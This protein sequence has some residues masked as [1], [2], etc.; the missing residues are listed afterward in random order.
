MDKI[1][2]GQQIKEVF[3]NPFDEKQFRY[4]I[5][6]LF[7]EIEELAEPPIA[8]SYIPDAFKDH[9]K[10]YKRIAKYTDPEGEKL[11]VLAV[12]LKKDHSIERART[13]QRNFLADYL[14]RRG[15]KD[16]AL[17][18]YYT[19]G[20]EDWRFSY[21]RMDYRIEKVD[22]GKVKVKTDLT[23]AR[24]Y[25]F[26][27]GKNE[28]SH[29]AQQQLVPLLQDIDNNP[30]LARIEQ[31]FNIESVTKEFYQKYKE[32]YLNL[33]DNCIEKEIKRSKQFREELNSKGIDEVSFTKKLLGQIV[34]LYF[35]QKK[36][37][38]GVP[39]DKTWGNGDRRYLRTL[40]DKAI[41]LNQNFY[42][43]Y[44]EYLF[45]QALATEHRGGSDSSYYPRFDC[46]IPF[47]NGGLFEADYDWEKT[48]ITIPNNL[49][50]NKNKTK[51]GDEGDGILD[52][53][54]R[55]N[56][57]VKEDEPLDKEVAV[58]PEMLGKVFENLLEV[59][60]RKSKGTY[61]TPREIV[62]YMCQESLI[63]YLDVTLNSHPASYIKIGDEQTDAF[64]N[65]TKKGQLDLEEKTG[66]VVK[67]PKND[68][69]E[70]IR[71]GIAALE[72]DVRVESKG[73]ETDRYFYQIPQS[74]RTHASELDEALET[75]R[76]CD[77]AIGS[78]A[79]PV[80]MMTEIV[81]ARQVLT[82]YLPEAYLK[83]SRQSY[84]QANRG[85]D[86]YDFKRHCIQECIYGVDIDHSAIDIAKLRL[87]LSLVVDEEDFYKIK[88]L[89]NLDYKIVEGN[90]LIGL[91]ENVFRDPK[92]ETEIEK[93]KI[94]FFEETDNDEKKKLRKQINE[95][96][97][98]LLDSAQE[99]T[100]YHVDFDFKLF[101]SEVFHDLP[102]DL[103]A[104]AGAKVEASAHAFQST[105]A[106]DRQAGKK[107]FDVVIGNPPYVEHKKL[108]AL[109]GQLKQIYKTY[110]GTA[111]LYVYF[112]EKGIN[113]L[114]NKGV[115]TFI[116]SNKFIKT[117][118]G[119]NLREYF[120][121]YKINEIIDFTDIHVF[122]ALVASC[123]FS[124]S[125][126]QADNNKI[127]IAFANDTLLNFSDLSTF[128]EQNKFYLNQYGLS[129][130]IWQLEN[131]TNLALK[132]K[133]ENGSLTINQTQTVKIFR[134]VTT[135]YNPAF[136]I[137]DD[138]R[139]ELI[140]EDK[141]NKAIIKPLLQGRNIRKWVF[142]NSNNFLLL[143]GYNINI[144]KEYPSVFNHLNNF[145]RELQERD[146]QGI[147][148]WNLRS[149]KYYSEFEKEK[150]IWGLTSD[151][152]TFAYDNENNFLPSNGYILTST[153]IPIK[154]LLALMN[155]KL[156]EFY[157]GFIGIMTAGGAFTLKY[158]TV[159]EF[160][161]KIIS[162][163]QQKP[164]ITLVV[165]I[166]EAKKS[167]AN[168]NT[169]ALE[170]EIDVMV[171]KL[172]GLTE[173]EIKIIEGRK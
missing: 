51:E 139:K 165:K 140:K 78:G 60:D 106:A 97:R 123:V 33:K 35:I 129:E 87:W 103:S 126:I 113:I 49:F 55:Y 19:D 43:N 99:F 84:N 80:G 20:V 26:L 127:K 152:W 14:K 70:F 162:E 91:P 119:E 108:K 125:K 3:E 110:S 1:Q 128:I 36:G 62:H 170:R 150:I 75:I 63:N 37:W 90:S 53:F 168:A 67:V 23:P 85:S 59:K 89:P 160:P 82:T 121:A 124:V 8:G 104:E 147:N 136:I 86:I 142:N 138:K 157:F 146:D 163:Q 96:I 93:L 118:Y 158:E 155:S 135:G 61:Y 153:E 73:K 151:K 131:E 133:I 9:V 112:Y 114:R 18:A 16:A 64:G 156:M 48:D 72:N 111:D 109:S 50:T 116:S 159:I 169:T 122:E 6:N 115:L 94:K 149:C 2:A 65:T 117:S 17:V 144:K 173:E 56:F 30:T 145:K 40:L 24:R 45:Y 148:W 83:K 13:M 143:T 88:P 27:V 161:I 47:L 28:P 7:N 11:D 57:T 107:G 132:E 74:I 167:D 44:L 4:F 137:D 79:F 141:A 71:H 171:Y 134:G 5:R 42:A 66:E 22:D 68:I 10:Q 34:F 31:A 166:L 15:E 77:P 69:E 92:I 101:F 46:K 32:L 105:C 95:K 12:S 39:K 100:G 76:I 81:K 164:F 154:Y 38:L 52:V 25:S 54:D 120:T 98:K 58:D 41:A 130:K 21:V 102:D 29:T 172:Y